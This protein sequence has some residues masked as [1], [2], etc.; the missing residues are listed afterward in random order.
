MKVVD[1]IKTE[2]SLSSRSFFISTSGFF[3]AALIYLMLPLII[4]FIGYL[5]IWWAV[6]FTGLF[7]AAAILA[8]RGFC[9]KPDGSL[10]DPKERS[11]EIKP[12]FLIFIIVLI[13]II[14][15]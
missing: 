6:L 4:F 11:I 7:G 12:A 14:L 15:Y 5:K 10:L 13:P 8:M 9:Q 2:K 3:K 1:S